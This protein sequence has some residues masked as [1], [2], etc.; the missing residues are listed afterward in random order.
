[1]KNIISFLLLENEDD[2]EVINLL[3]ELC[4]H[5]PFEEFIKEERSV[6]RSLIYIDINSVVPLRKVKNVEEVYLTL[7]EKSQPS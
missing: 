7:L 1:M 4:F 2:G 6:L 5:Y 3:G